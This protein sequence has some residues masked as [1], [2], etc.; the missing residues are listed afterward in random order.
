MAD[1]QENANPFHGEGGDGDGA[2][3]ETTDA[4]GGAVIYKDDDEILAGLDKIDEEQAKEKRRKAAATSPAPKKKAKDDDEDDEGEGEGEKPK[5]AKPKAAKDDDEPDNDDSEEEDDDKGDDDADDDEPDEKSDDDETDVEDETDDDKDAGEPEPEGDIEEKELAKL[6]REKKRRDEDHRRRDTELRQR[7]TAFQAERTTWER[8]RTELQRSKQEIESLSARVK[9][10]PQAAI[11]LLRKLGM[12]KEA[13]RVTEPDWQR[14]WA[15]DMGAVTEVDGVR[16]ELDEMKAKMAEQEK[17][18]GERAQAEKTKQAVI[19]FI[20]ETARG[21]KKDRHPLL[22]EMLKNDARAAK[23]R[24]YQVA[25]EMARKDPSNPPNKKIVAAEAERRCRED[26]KRMG[27]KVASKKTEPNAD[28][29]RTAKPKTSQKQTSGRAAERADEDDDEDDNKRL[30]RELNEFD[31][32]KAAK[33][34]SSAR[35]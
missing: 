20:D 3:V 27:F 2:D 5:K 7:E 16:R 1:Q 13:F 35:R 22:A 26:A 6:H 9:G 34:K 12:T 8:E 29:I 19:G 24:L 15:D 28:E 30:L 21:V 11:A 17:K 31:E 10:S 18:A 14:F 23:S 33:K 25:D 32:R 4:P